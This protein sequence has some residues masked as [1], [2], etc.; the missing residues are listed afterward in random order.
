MSRRVGIRGHLP[1]LPL[2]QRPGQRE[3]RR[4]P[5]ALGE[6]RDAFRGVPTDA[7]LQVLPGHGSDIETQ[8]VFDLTQKR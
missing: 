5:R 7:R 6:L 3:G 2:Q 4:V 1:W 8:N